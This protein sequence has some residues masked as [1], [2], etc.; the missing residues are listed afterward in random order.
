MSDIIKIEIP[1]MERTIRAMTRG[2]QHLPGE[3]SAAI[4]RAVNRTLDA[5]RAEAIRV[6]REAYTY[7]PPGRVFDRL[8]LK[9]ATRSD[10]TG[11]LY[12]RGEKGANLWHFKPSPKLPGK[13]PSEGVSA[14]VRRQGTR[15]V[16]VRSGWSA[17]FIMKKRR[18]A[19]KDGGYGVFIR[20]DG[21]RPGA[22]NKRRG[23]KNN[24]KDLEMLFGASPI[25]SVWASRERLQARA[26]ETFAKRLRHEVNA[27]L[28]GHIRGGK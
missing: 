28:A 5:V 25:Q 21:T 20:K 3:C 16:R 19:N 13:R 26:R 24:W 22:V 14:K 1:D 7:V 27:I 8:Y 9:K 11:C 23:T 4:A 17:P 15:S 6:A 18:G 2:M 10:G 12:I